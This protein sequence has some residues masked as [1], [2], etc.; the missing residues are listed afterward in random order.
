MIEGVASFAVLIITLESY[1]KDISPEVRVELDK[2]GFINCCSEKV[3][4]L[5]AQQRG[6]DV[7]YAAESV[8]A[9]ELVEYAFGDATAR[10]RSLANF[11]E[12]NTDVSWRL[13]AQALEPAAPSDYPKMIV[14]IYHRAQELEF[15]LH[16]MTRD[17]DRWER[18]FESMHHDIE[19]R[20]HA[21]CVELL[22][23]HLVEEKASAEKAHQMEME[24][25]DQFLE[26]FT[27]LND[28]D[29][30]YN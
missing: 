13:V 24:K 8:F 30:V 1:A 9:D 22:R 11:A 26:Q 4:E 21:K 25:R 19:K 18:R 15:E 16:K 10:E 17:R 27:I 5:R 29:M 14:N 7:E 12:M 6:D 3:R 23:D 28:P 20:E 2:A